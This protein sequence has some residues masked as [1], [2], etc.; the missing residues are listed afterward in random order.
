MDIVKCVLFWTLINCALYIYNVYN[1][2]W[3][4]RE[5][6]SGFDPSTVAKMGDKEI[7]DISSNKA[8]MLA[9]SRV[10]CILDNAKC[11]LKA[12][13]FINPNILFSI[14]SYNICITYTWGTALSTHFFHSS[15]TIF[16][17]KYLILSIYKGGAQI[18]YAQKTKDKPFSTLY[19]GCSRIWIFQ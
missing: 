14:I 16:I 7:A 15:V 9:E 10:R 4:F 8:I 17:T 19:L 13:F 5:A 1:T 12:N 18:V 6:F 11:I 2:Y 3:V